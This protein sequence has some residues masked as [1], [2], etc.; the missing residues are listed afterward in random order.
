MNGGAKENLVGEI[1]TGKELR[2]VYDEVKKGE[3]LREIE[4][5][6]RNLIEEVGF[7]K[8]VIGNI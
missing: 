3:E 8:S 4:K 6:K 5:E 1:S 7:L 2:E